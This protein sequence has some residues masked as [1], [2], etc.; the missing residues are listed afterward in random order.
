MDGMTMIS[1]R[2]TFA[3]LGGALVARTMRPARAQALEKFRLQT[4]WRAQA[5]HGGF[6]Q[7]LATGLYR[8]V[9]V[10]M[11]VRMGGPQVDSN[12]SL[13]NGRVEMATGTAFTGLN[14]VRAD[15]PFVVV[16][17]TFQKD[18]RI[19]ISHPG[20]G[21]DALPALRGK[22]VLVATLGRNTYWPWL[23]TRF[24]FT[25]E[26][27]RPYTFSLAPFL[28]NPQVSVQ[29]LS[30]SE[31]MDVRRAGIEPVVHHLADYGWLDYQ[32][33]LTASR[34]MVEEK[35]DLIRRVLA[36]TARGWRSYL[37]GDPAPG[38]RLIKEANPD[39]DDAKI[40]FAIQSMRDG[41]LVEGGDAAQLGIGAMTEERWRRFYDGVVAD[42]TVPAG[43]DVS[44]AYTLRCL[45]GTAS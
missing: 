17:T 29:G 37:H 31:P 42:G 18:T 32:Q 30:T 13:F 36:A 6:Y 16:A 41:S 14:Y 27:V 39:M 11:E 43:L 12:A 20:V 19:L 26:Q 28:A 8:D 34:R 21:H 15:V 7:A 4:G 3:C 10:D 38:N 44:R 40:A 25:D 5:E 22:P 2:T 23:R 33:T 45:P 1:R 9:G 24:G 35:P